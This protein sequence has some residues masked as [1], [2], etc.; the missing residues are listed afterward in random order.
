MYLIYVP[1]LCII[2]LCTYQYITSYLFAQPTTIGLTV[3]LCSSLIFNCLA[4]YYLRVRALGLSCCTLAA[5]IV[6][7]HRIRAGSWKHIDMTER[8]SSSEAS[9]KPKAQ[10]TNHKS[11]YSIKYNDGN[12]A[13]RF[14]GLIMIG[15]ARM[16]VEVSGFEPPKIAAR[17]E[18]TWSLHHHHQ[19]QQQQQQQRHSSSNSNNRARSSH[20]SLKLSSLIIYPHSAIRLLVTHQLSSRSSSPSPYVVGIEGPNVD[21]QGFFWLLAIISV[22][23]WHHHHQQQ[24]Q[25]QGIRLPQQQQKESTNAQKLSHS[26]FILIQFLVTSTLIQILIT[27]TLCCG[28]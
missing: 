17:T 22:H 9:N 24:Q 25:R 11:Q 2:L 14:L 20:H 18:S 10:T 3:L 6:T 27:F 21:Q 7:L 26:S 13:R 28:N 1:L 16:V 19:Q 15:F 23:A 4:I 5:S 8:A 12:V